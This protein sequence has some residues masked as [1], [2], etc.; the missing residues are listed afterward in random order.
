MHEYV[1]PGLG[2][3]AYLDKVELLRV[4][5]G[6][7]Q[8]AGPVDNAHNL[9]VVRTATALNLPFTDASQ[10]PEMDWEEQSTGTTA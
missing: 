5:G 4:G 2:P 1:C 6:A 3:T 10:A 7:G 8:Q 9:R